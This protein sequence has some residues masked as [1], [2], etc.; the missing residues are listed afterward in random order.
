VSAGDAPNRLVWSGGY[1]L[2][3]GRGKR[4]G[5]SMNR[6]ANGVVG[7]WQ[8]NGILSFQSGQ[9][10]NFGL[11]NPHLADGNQRPDVTGNPRSSYTIKDVVDGRGL[12]VNPSAYSSPPDQ[13]PGNAPR[14]DGR[15]RGNGIN[16]LDAS[17]FKDFKIREGMKLQFR[18]EF[19]NFTNTPRFDNPNTVVGSPTFGTIYGQY[20]Q[21]RRIQ[22]AVRFTF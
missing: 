13:I 10:L 2:P 6:W 20:N 7:G 12:I 22:M 18:G 21:P 3:V 19:I 9:P 11:A 16:N 8:I 4:I 17:I 14:Y 5:N 15:V 1:E